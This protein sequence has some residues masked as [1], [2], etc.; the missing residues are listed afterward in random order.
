MLRFTLQTRDG[1]LGSDYCTDHRNDQLSV[2]ATRD[3]KI[4]SVRKLCA[5]DSSRR[6]DE[7]NPCDRT[8]TDLEF[9]LDFRGA[10]LPNAV[11]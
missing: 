2:G 7:L 3:C 5:I 4:T 9:R 8:L 6:T 10:C 1:S 11:S